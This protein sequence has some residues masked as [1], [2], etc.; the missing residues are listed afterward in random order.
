MTYRCEETL[1]TL[2]HALAHR[3]HFKTKLEPTRCPLAQCS[4]SPRPSKSADVS[5]ANKGSRS[6]GSCF[7]DSTRTSCSAIAFYSKLRE[8]LYVALKFNSSSSGLIYPNTIMK[9]R[10]DTWNRL[11]AE[12][13][14][15]RTNTGDACTRKKKGSA[16]SEIIVQK[17]ASEPDSKQAYR[18]VQPREFVDLQ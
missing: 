8:L 7:F 13:G 4:L 18:P 15:K 17:L 5:R 2:V 16:P 6:C 1:R 11:Q 3:S 12:M 10:Q 14:Q 9:R